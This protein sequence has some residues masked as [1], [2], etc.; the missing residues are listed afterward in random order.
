MD[1]IYDALKALGFSGLDPMPF[2][3]KKILYRKAAL[4]AFNKIKN[5]YP[6]IKEK[7]LGPE[8]FDFKERKHKRYFIGNLLRQILIDRRVKPTGTYDDIYLRY[9]KIKKKLSRDMSQKP[10]KI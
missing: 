3:E 7:F 4:N 6:L 9:L 1:K 10:E 8:L 2:D 5:E